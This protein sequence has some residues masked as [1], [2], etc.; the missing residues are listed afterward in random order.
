[1]TLIE[2]YMILKRNCLYEEFITIIANKKGTN[3]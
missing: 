1:M 2:L 3:K